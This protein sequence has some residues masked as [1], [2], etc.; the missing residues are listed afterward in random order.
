[1]RVIHRHV[2]ATTCVAANLY[3]LGGVRQT[4]AEKSGLEA[5][6]LDASERGT[7]KYPEDALR[8]RMASLGSAIVS[9]PSE[10]WT[11]FG[12]R[13]TTA[14]FDSTWRCSPTG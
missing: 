1:V 5:I 12:L 7:R 14:T 8:R 13:S 2:T 3:L 10:D 6:L 11:L 4:P 9:A